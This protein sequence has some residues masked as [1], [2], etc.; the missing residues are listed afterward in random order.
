MAIVHHHGLKHGK[1]RHDILRCKDDLKKYRQ[2]LDCYKRKCIQKYRYEY[3]Q[4]VDRYKRR[5]RDALETKLQLT[6]T[7]VK[8]PHHVKS[9]HKR[10]PLAFITTST[11]VR[12]NPWE[13]PV[14][15][16]RQSSQPK[17]I[18]SRPTCDFS[19]YK[20]RYPST[21]GEFK[22]RPIMKLDTTIELLPKTHSSKNDNTDMN[23]FCSKIEYI[24][25]IY[26]GL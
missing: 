9:A 13:D 8:K 6:P 24:D 20:S 21:R 25:P 14:S 12:N 22:S 16:I 10:T 1:H 19:K 15:R 26:K 3:K 11:S 4:E 23:P 5:I 18:Y 7:R 2:E 17:R